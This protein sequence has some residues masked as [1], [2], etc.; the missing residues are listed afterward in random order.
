MATLDK[1]IV[2]PP[3]NT[4]HTKHHL[5]GNEKFLHGT[6]PQTSCFFKK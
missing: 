4:I 2:T 1:R 6:Y 5:K 3:Q